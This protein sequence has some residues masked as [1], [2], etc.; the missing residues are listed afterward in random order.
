MMVVVHVLP[1]TRRWRTALPLLV[2]AVVA[3]GGCAGPSTVRGSA[4][5]AGGGTD[6][7]PASASGGDGCP[8]AGVLVE[9]GPVDGAAG[10]RA[11]TLSL[12]NCGPSPYPV[13]GFPGLRLLDEQQDVVA[14]TVLEDLDPVG[15]GLDLPAELLDLAPGQTAEAV[16]LWRNTVELGL[17]NTPGSYL[18]VT[19]AP[20]ATEQVVALDVDL[21]TTGRL[22]TGPWRPGS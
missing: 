22:T 17:P 12:V 18:A 11:V 9:V 15:A 10:L 21:G 7:D 2:A 3:L 14:V 8:P 19:P 16:L 13:E 20:G 4:A 6:D 1:T 5:P